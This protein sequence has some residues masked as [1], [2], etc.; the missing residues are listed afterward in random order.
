MYTRTLNKATLLGKL[1]LEPELFHTPSG[2]AYCRMR[3]LTSYSYLDIDGKEQVKKQIHHITAWGRQAEISA[4][5]LHVNS[6]IYVEGHIEYDEWIAKDGTPKK[7][8]EI[9]VHY[10][11]ILSPTRRFVKTST[12]PTQDDPLDALPAPSE[13]DD[14]PNLQGD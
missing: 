4:E 9:H 3:L 12:T 11:L 1:T 5:Y 8:T 6:L 2:K 10:M 13:T 14:L 7:K